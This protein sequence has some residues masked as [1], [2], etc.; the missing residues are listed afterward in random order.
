MGFKVLQT[1]ESLATWWGHV[2]KCHSQ[3]CQHSEALLMKQTS[4]MK[5]IASK[6]LP[7]SLGNLYQQQICF[8]NDFHLFLLQVSLPSTCS[9]REWPPQAS[10]P[11]HLLTGAM[12]IRGSKHKQKAAKAGSPL[13]LGMKKW[14][15]TSS[16][17]YFLAF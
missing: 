9:D 15:K 3:L 8:I 7:T 5:A 4:E 12:S 11:V 1:T 14:H 16:E 6:A 17:T 2:K 13:T 10:Y